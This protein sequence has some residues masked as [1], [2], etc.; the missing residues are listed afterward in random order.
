M[1]LIS[2]IDSWNC[3]C[4]DDQLTVN[5][6]THK[7]RSIKINDNELPFSTELDNICKLFKKMNKSYLCVDKE[8]L[9]IIYQWGIILYQLKSLICVEIQTMN[10]II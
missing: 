8:C 6:I 1:S 2:L 10:L 7:I 9:S 3:L 4:L 5:F